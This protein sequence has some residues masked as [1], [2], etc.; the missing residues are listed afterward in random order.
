MSA[1]QIL[2]RLLLAPS[3]RASS[4]T[5]LER[6]RRQL[7]VYRQANESIHAEA[8]TLVRERVDLL[9]KVGAST[10]QA[11]VLD[12]VRYV[13]DG[14]DD[15]TDLEERRDRFLEEALE[16]F[17][18]LAGTRAAARRLVAYVFS[19][20]AGVPGQEFGGTK[21]TLN[22]LA[23]YAGEDLLACGEA[24][25]ARTWRPE[26]VSK[27]RRK[28]SNRHGRGPLPGDDADLVTRLTR[29]PAPVLWCVHVIGPDDLHPAPDLLT[30]IAWAKQFNAW[31]EAANAGVPA[32]DVV[33]C[34]ASVIEWEGTAESHAEGLPAAIAGMTPRK[35][36]PAE[37]ALVSP[38]PAGA[39]EVYGQAYREARKTSELDAHVAGLRAVCSLLLKVQEEKLVGYLADLAKEARANG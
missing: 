23:S 25:L 32:E 14:A 37:V 11:R 28:R 19:R 21:T 34:Y 17:Q 30:A 1:R 13:C 3:A 18:S 2:A 16:L 15:P 31:S 36:A 6:L 10:F 4:E 27:I 26:V 7:E 8:A 12:H 35:A 29:T 24:E 5:E 39:L 33:L 9:E 22:A 38:L 20:P